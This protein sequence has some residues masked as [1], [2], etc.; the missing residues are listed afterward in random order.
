[1]LFIAGL[2]PLSQLEN[3]GLSSAD[4]CSCKLQCFAQIQMPDRHC[5]TTC[6]LGHLLHLPTRK[7]VFWWRKNT[8]CAEHVG[9]C[10]KKNPE[11]QS[12]ARSSLQK[13]GKTFS[14]VLSGTEWVLQFYQHSTVLWGSDTWFGSRVQNM[15][16]MKPGSARSVFMVS[17]NQLWQPCVNDHYN[18]ADGSHTAYLF[19]TTEIAFAIAC[20]FCCSVLTLPY[21]AQ[22]LFT[23]LPNANCTV[24]AACAQLKRVIVSPF[25][26]YSTAVEA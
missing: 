11:Y 16:C 7:M 6:F 19:T 22:T 8:A 15:T 1:M 10:P 24:T 21:S 9:F 23:S 13:F 5:I 14:A 2:F 20:A 26:N 18:E 3:S 17:L 25:L 4:G 12:S